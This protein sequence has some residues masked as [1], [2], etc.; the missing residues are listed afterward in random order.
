MSTLDAQ[1]ICTYWALLSIVKSKEMFKFLNLVWSQNR[2]FFRRLCDARAKMANARLKAQQIVVVDD[3]RVRTAA[4][5]K[6]Y[7]I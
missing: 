7:W 4:S 6:S 3:L 1:C 5:T 2:F